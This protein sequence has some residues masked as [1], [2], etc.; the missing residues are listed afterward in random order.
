MAQSPG[1]SFYQ[2]LGDVFRHHGL[3]RFVVG[4]GRRA[5]VALVGR[6]EL[7]MPTRVFDSPGSS[8]SSA[9]LVQAGAGVADMTFRKKT[10]PLFGT[11][12]STRL[13]PYLNDAYLTRLAVACTPLDGPSAREAPTPGRVSSLL[14]E[15]PSSRCSTAFPRPSLPVAEA[16]FPKANHAL[17]CPRQLMRRLRPSLPWTSPGT[18]SFAPGLARRF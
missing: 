5:T 15:L 4:L 17:Y 3:D 12:V 16:S 2:R 8:V 11:V 18:A 1:H 7:Q 6:H 9:R 10:T 13:G 14:F